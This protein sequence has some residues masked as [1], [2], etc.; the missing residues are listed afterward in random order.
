MP[1]GAQILALFS[2][3]AKPSIRALARKLSKLFSIHRDRE[4][5]CTRKLPRAITRNMFQVDLDSHRVILPMPSIINVPER[6]PRYCSQDMV[7]IG[8]CKP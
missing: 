4:A 2:P 8:I 1:Y 6:R 3:K 7:A 5:R